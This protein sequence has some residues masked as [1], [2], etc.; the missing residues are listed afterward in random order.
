M[1]FHRITLLLSTSS[2]L[3]TH[4]IGAHNSIH[5]AKCKVVLILTL[6]FVVSGAAV[7]SDITVRQIEIKS[8][9]GGLGTPQ[10]SEVLIRNDNGIFW[11]GRKQVDEHAVAELISALRSDAV[12]K[13]DA[14]N[15]GFTPEWLQANADSAALKARGNFADALPEQNPFI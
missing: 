10:H 7:A 9:W 13:P 5:M 4:G 11:M 12:P 8:G 2:L 1:V 3:G 15:L 6:L 14:T